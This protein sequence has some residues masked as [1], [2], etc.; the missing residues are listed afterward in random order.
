[1]RIYAEGVW[2]EVENA[3]RDGVC[4]VAD[5]GCRK[6]V[7]FPVTTLKDL[8]VVKEVAPAAMFVHVKRSTRTGKVTY[9]GTQ[10]PRYAVVKDASQIQDA[11]GKMI[12]WLGAEQIN[13][14]SCGEVWTVEYLPTKDIDTMRRELLTNGE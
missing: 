9:V 6:G 7:R 8:L 4:I 12:G 3:R 2:H 1:V 11:S 13:V 5:V 14:P 10:G